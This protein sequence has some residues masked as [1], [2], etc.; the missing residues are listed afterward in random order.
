M[1]HCFL[2][3]NLAQQ[4]KDHNKH[5]LR[6]SKTVPTKS[7]ETKQNHANVRMTD[8][9]FIAKTCLLEILLFSNCFFC[10]Y[11]ISHNVIILPHRNFTLVYYMYVLRF[12]MILFSFAMKLYGT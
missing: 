11:F 2:D 4:L 5:T 12:T 6:V 7:T 9:F 10:N 1:L 8:K 3:K